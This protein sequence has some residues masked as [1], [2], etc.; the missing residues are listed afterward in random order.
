V[1][2]A[3]N[4]SGTPETTVTCKQLYDPNMNETISGCDDASFSYQVD[5][6]WPDSCKLRSALESLSDP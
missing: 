2:L 1:N 5:E 4:Y 6:G 3:A